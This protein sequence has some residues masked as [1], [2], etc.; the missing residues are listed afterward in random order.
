MGKIKYFN[1]NLFDSNADVLCHQVNVYGVM[2]AGIAAEVRKRFPNVNKEYE[3]FCLQFKPYKNYN[4]ILGKVVIVETNK[5][6]TQFIANCFSQDIE[7]K[8][9][10]LTNYEA[11]KDCL[12]YIESWMKN[13]NKLTVAFPYKYG[14]GIA[15]GDWE[16]VKKIIYDSFKD[17]DITVEIWN[18][19]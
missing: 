1:G 12:N 10:C 7:S 13:K 15:G 14:C 16:I 5:K 18:L 9:G 19:S 3:R 11:L 6:K 2:G 17:V 4:D 8:D